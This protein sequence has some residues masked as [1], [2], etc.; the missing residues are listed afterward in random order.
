MRMCSSSQAKARDPEALSVGALRDSSTTLRSAGMTGNSRQHRGF[1]PGAL[2]GER[3]E[4]VLMILSR[5]TC[6]NRTAQSIR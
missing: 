6:L 1:E 2:R 4:A 5:D 3:N